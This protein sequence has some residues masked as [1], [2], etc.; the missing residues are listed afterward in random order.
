MFKGLC[1]CYV[2]VAMTFFSV[3]ISGYW[4][5]GNQADGLILSN[6]LDNDKRPLVPKWLVL[7][8]NMFT[9]LQLSAV[10]LVRISISHHNTN[11]TTFFV[12]TTVKVTDYD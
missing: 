9:L 5:F 10:A 4:A 7:I 3:A 1:I 8:T 6:F 2:I 12:F 11:F